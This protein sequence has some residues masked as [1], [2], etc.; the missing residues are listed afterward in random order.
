MRNAVVIAAFNS[1][2]YSSVHRHGRLDAQGWGEEDD[3]VT[4]DEKQVERA[5]LDLNNNSEKQ[6][7]QKTGNTRKLNEAY[8]YDSLRQKSY[9]IS[10]EY[11]PNELHVDER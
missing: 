1:G 4:T 6:D 11:N 10:I 5:L 2:V 9:E 3:R 8:T 7:K